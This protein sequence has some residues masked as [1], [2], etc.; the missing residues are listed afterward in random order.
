VNVGLSPTEALKGLRG[1]L[2]LYSC[3]GKATLLEF[4]EDFFADLQRRWNSNTGELAA[5]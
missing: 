2:K 4:S 3:F 5:I 1:S